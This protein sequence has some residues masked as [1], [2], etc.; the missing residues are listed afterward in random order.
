[1]RSTRARWQGGYSRALLVGLFLRATFALTTFALALL[2]A[3]R[4]TRIVLSTI[5][6]NSTI[7]TSSLDVFGGFG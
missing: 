4:R 2:G 6:T 5:D 1:M 3:V 7:T